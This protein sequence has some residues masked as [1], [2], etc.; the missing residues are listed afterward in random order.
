VKRAALVAG[1]VGVAGLVAAQEQ[2]TPLEPGFEP[3]VSQRG[4]VPREPVGDA[5]VL[6]VDVDGSVRADGRCLVPV[7]AETES[8]G[9]ARES[10][11]RWLSPLAAT[12]PVEPGTDGLFGAPLRAGP[13]RVRAHRDAP[14][15]RVRL[16]LEACTRPT[17]RVAR[18]D[19]AVRA[20]EGAP[21]AWLA[22]RLPRYGEHGGPGIGFEPRVLAQGNWTLACV[23][24]GLRSVATDAAPGRRLEY[25]LG[26]R[27]TMDPET[28]AARA[29][30]LR[31][32]DPGRPFLM[33]PDADIRCGEVVTVLDLLATLD[34][35]PAFARPV[36]LTD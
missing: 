18:V 2:R 14:F 13:L 16:V 10:L 27:R 5:H 6:R 17:A 7:P 8:V 22:L 30:V 28:F 25:H 1:L 33:A 35:E 11:G 36:G 26:P 34:I 24:V 21:E 19:L 12:M 3:P 9:A 31:D 20:E 29:R 32:E 23:E 15:A 4:V